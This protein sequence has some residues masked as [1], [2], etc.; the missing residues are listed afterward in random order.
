M[1]RIPFRTGRAALP[2]AR[3]ASGW[4]LPWT[5]ALSVYLAGLG[6]T[7]LVTLG[8]SMRGWDASLAHKASLQVPADASAARLNTALALLRQTRGIAEARLLDPVETAR[9]VE[10]WLG[11]SVAIDRLP[12]PRLIDL[13]VDGAGAADLADLRQ[14]L[15]SIMPD[16]V[17]DDHGLLL[18]EWR[19]AATRT[20]AAIAAML[21]AVF[22]ITLWSAAATARAGLLLD[23]PLVEL[24]QLLGA[25]D[26]DIAWPFQARAWWLGLLGGA[27]GALVA[28]LTLA[29]VGSAG[30][31]LPLGS[32]LTGV[33]IMDWRVWAIL[34]GATALAGFIAMAAARITVL[35]RLARMP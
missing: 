21:A 12:V 10:P 34:L 1:I 35:R 16:A 23:H 27:G 24:L 31:A 28:A 17:L 2:L 8:D 32:P 19:N 7:G 25:V 15:A 33:G 3:R 30:R 5:V 13:R 22:L 20:M 9:L 6:G 18:D 29:T 26:A 4:I 14:K 11:R